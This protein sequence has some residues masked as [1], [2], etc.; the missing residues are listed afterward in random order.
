MRNFLFLYA[1]EWGIEHNITEKII[2]NR[3]GVSGV[4][5]GQQELQQLISLKQLRPLTSYMGHWPSLFGQARSTLP[6]Y[7]RAITHSKFI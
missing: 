2:A 3:R 7:P 4:G 1:R 6:R 5:D